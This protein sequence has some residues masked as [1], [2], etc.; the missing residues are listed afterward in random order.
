VPPLVLPIFPLPQLTFFPHT[1]LPLHVFEAR[2]RA[3]VGDVLPGTKRLLIVGLQPG[4][5]ESYAGKPP[6]YQVAGLGEIV[7]WERL[8][9]GRYNIVV[10]GDA[11]ARI[12]AE[13]P[14]DTLY[15][16]VRADRLDDV[17]PQRDVAPLVE[18]IR[19]QCRHLLAALDR[20]PDLLAEALRDGQEP[21]AIADQIASAVLPDPLLRQELLETLDA[22][23]RLELLA[24]ALEDLVRQVT[25]AR[26]PDDRTG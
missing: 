23:R 13:L 16:V 18:R 3:M 24:T 2:Y 20:S 1:L 15:R 4:F 5:E 9:T 14:S 8:A 7:Q 22:E 21:G 12:M 26:R 6:V 10:Q 17:R 19:A 11:R 25:R